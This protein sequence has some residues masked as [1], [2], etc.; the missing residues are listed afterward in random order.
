MVMKSKGLKFPKEMLDVV[1]YTHNHRVEG[2]IHYPPGGRLS[3]FMNFGP[4]AMFIAVT[5]AKIYTLTGEE[6]LHA[7]EFLDIN[8]NQ[9]T[10]IFPMP[11]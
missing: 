6:P 9:I 8:R 5:R 4:E 2:K 1:I 10:M 7:I 11:H 3:D